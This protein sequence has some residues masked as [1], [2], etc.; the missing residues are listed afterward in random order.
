[1][2]A[3]PPPRHQAEQHRLHPDGVPKLMDFG[4][5]RV[6]GPAAGRPAASDGEERRVGRSLS[7]TCAMETT[8][9]TSVTLSASW[10][11]PSP[12]S[13]RG[14]ER[15]GAEPAFDLWGLAVVLYEC[16][17]G[18]SSSPGMDMKQTLQRI[19]QGRVPDYEQ[20]CPDL[21]PVL[22]Q[23]F[24]GALHPHPG[25]AAGEPPRD[26]AA[27]GRGAGAAHRA[28][29]PP[30][31][32]LRRS[33]RAWRFGRCAQPVAGPRNRRSPYPRTVRPSRSPA[34]WSWWRGHSIPQGRREARSWGWMR[35]SR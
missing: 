13:R 6:P 8:P 12:T 20:T 25:A 28:L 10:W 32:S 23:F 30:R 29:S 26:E 9:A 5:R 14:A 7:P 1:M 21:D 33:L 17:L 19:R 27:P 22:G 11:A 34:A 16:I 24:R 2:A 3:H 15:R 4:H 18:A 35:G 31:R